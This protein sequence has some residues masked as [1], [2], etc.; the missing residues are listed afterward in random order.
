[1]AEKISSRIRLVKILQIINKSSIEEPVEVAEI[2]E[3]LNAEGIACNRKTIYSDLRDLVEA[4]IG[5]A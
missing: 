5:K 2:V 4:D 1:M 3:A